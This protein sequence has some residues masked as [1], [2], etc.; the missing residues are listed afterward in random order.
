[1]N[2]VNKK[3]NKY[4]QYVVTVALN[5]QEIKKDRQRITKIKPFI[6]KYNQE[7]INLPSEKD[8]WKKIE[9]NN[10]TINLNVFYAK[11]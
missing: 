2:P 6:N 11:K 5:Y 10:V 8:D 4:V 1:M 3:D 9:K 7:G